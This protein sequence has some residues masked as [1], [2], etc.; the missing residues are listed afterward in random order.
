MKKLSEIVHYLNELDKLDLDNE[1][2]STVRYMDH[3]FHVATAFT[4]QIHERS[5][6]L[7]RNVED[8]K[9]AI[10]RAQGTLNGLKQQLRQLISS[11][12]QELYD[13][14]TRW[15][16][17]ESCFETTDL[18]LNRRMGID[19]E[20]VELL[21]ARMKNFTDWRLP[22]M[23]MRPGLE[24]FIIDLVAL[25]PLYLVDHSEELI[26]F[27]MDRFTP[28]YQRRLRPYVVKEFHD[29][30]IL[31]KLPVGQFGF[32]L[33]YNFFNYKPMELIKRYLE[34]LFDK[35]R[36][37]GTIIMTINDCDLAHGV[38][39][40]EKSFMCY[41]PGTAICRYAESLGYELMYRHTGLGDLNW[42]ELKRPGE[43]TSLRGGQ[44]L[45]KIVALSK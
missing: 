3:V 40:A 34:E 16:E 18:I 13:Q 33:A 17:Q 2:L 5:V 43:I 42:L 39:L 10:G 11:R 22:G 44:T 37:G 24:P 31:E 20:S 7:N 21:K 41:T 38:A 27:S 14:S 15:L 12:E 29:N 36:P 19:T 45:A 8:V 6:E 9:Q 26:T 35:L 28:E 4:F 32:V 1:S 25:D 30:K 23:I